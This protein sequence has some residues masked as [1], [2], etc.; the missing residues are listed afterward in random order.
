MEKLSHRA[1]QLHSPQA[2]HLQCLHAGARAPMHCTVCSIKE[3]CFAKK[4][5]A[6][7]V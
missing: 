3:A 1:Q 5:K 2:D 6:S 4:L 7:I